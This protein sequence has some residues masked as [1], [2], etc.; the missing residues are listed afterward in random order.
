MSLVVVLQHD[1]V[2]PLRS[3]LVAPLAETTAMKRVDRI[4]P[5][6]VIEGKPYILAMD[7]IATVDLADLG[8]QVGSVHH[9]RD[10]IVAAIDFLFTGV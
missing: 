5:T 1:R 3:R 6:V 4:H 9:L 7:Q 10:E 2:S 8:Q